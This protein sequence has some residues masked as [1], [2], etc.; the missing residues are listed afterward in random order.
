MKKIL[1]FS[2]AYYPSFVS[3]AEAA[4]KE[5]T[6]RID[7]NDTEFHLITL[8]F[9]TKA[10]KVEKLGHVTV[11]RVGF[12]GNYLSKIL[13]VPLAALTARALHKTYHF[14][15]LWSVMTYMLFPV[16]LSRFL[17]VSAPHVL[18]L[19]DGDPYERVFERWFMRPLTPLLDD[20]F[21]NAAIIHVISS[22]LG[23][24]PRK[25]GYQGEIVLIHNGANPRN[26][27]EDYP[28]EEAET[29][30]KK[31]DKQ[32]GDVFLLNA[33]RLVYQKAHDDVIR[34]LALLPDNVKFVLIGGGPDED[35]LKELAKKEG[36][37][38]R[39]FFIGPLEREDVPLY[40]NKTVAD[41]FVGPSRSEGLGNSF[42]S[43]MAARL[44]VI[45]T[46][47]GG[48]AEFVFDEKRNSSKETTAW[49]VDKNSPDQIAQA[50]NDILTRPEKVKEVTDRARQMVLEKYNW[51]VI[52]KEMREKVFAK[53]L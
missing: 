23:T 27:S 34:A 51:D 26:L 33:A 18:T 37:A 39:V 29:L 25:R 21:R 48:L 52:A 31:L 46:Q 6:D 5:V 7:A 3:G 14:D 28:K 49:A 38:E 32:E 17:G 15:A 11:H 1:I 35:M 16:V 22:F 41:I 42:L 13:F 50:V 47:E 36:V 40:R 4:I 19:Q 44:P 8:L 20:G 24:W 45:T 30:K 10:P 9:D 43:A 2:L 12:G 53:V